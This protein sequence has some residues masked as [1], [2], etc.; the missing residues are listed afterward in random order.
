MWLVATVPGNADLGH[1]HIAE[2]SIGS[3]DPG[4]PSLDK[5]T[6]L[7]FLLSHIKR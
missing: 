5:V 7:A 4:L 6:S 3:A 1:F 2:S